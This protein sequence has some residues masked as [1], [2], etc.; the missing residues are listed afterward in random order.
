MEVSYETL[1]KEVGKRS[2]A[3]IYHYYVC[4]QVDLPDMNSPIEFSVLKGFHSLESALDFTKTLNNIFY[5]D[6]ENS[7]ITVTNEDGDINFITLDT[8]FV[9]RSSRWVELKLNG[10]LTIDDEI[11]EI[12]WLNE[13]KKL[14]NKSE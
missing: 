2:E 3:W 11:R 9:V 1:C 6:C 13:I 14:R 8:D 4:S 7:Y 10:E 5:E 12:R